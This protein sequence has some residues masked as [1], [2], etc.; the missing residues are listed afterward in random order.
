MDGE[1]TR[2]TRPGLIPTDSS[3]RATSGV[4]TGP[5]LD[6][7]RLGIV[8]TGGIGTLHAEV[9][10]RIP[11]IEL[12]ALSG[13]DPDAPALADRLGVPLESDFGALTGHGVEAVIVAVPNQLHETVG[14]HFAAR[15]V[16][17]LVEKPIA[18]SL[19]AGKAL[20]ASAETHGVHLIVGQH[21]RYNNLVR[22]AAEVVASEIG[23]LVATSAMV[24][25]RK[26][27]SYYEPDWRRAAGSGPLLVNLI[28]EVDLQRAVCGEI[29]RVQ[30]V[31]SNRARGFAFDDTAAV[32]LHF[33]SGALGTMVVTE[34]TPSPWSWEASVSEGMG[35]HNAGQDNASFLGTK[36]SLSF[37]SMTLWGYDDADGEPGWRSPLHARRVTVT[38]NEPYVDQ[39]VHLARVVRGLEAPHVPGAEGLRSLAVVMAVVEA[40][41]TG[42]VID[43][44]EL[45]DAA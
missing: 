38:P 20:C 34:S 24:A 39:L 15:G 16:H 32:L 35:F 22:T 41:S 6:P 42:A 26:P 43:V 37:P 23:T 45:L 10:A 14:L 2:R 33:R 1:R 30:A 4:A 44:G 8:G 18:D 11:E 12:V 28:H 9:A 7:V 3:P 25:M 29:D 5:D 27:D 17:L 36:R 21:R 13:L 31:A 40:A 19:P